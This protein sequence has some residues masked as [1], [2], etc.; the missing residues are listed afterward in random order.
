MHPYG[1]TALNHALARAAAM[2][3]AGFAGGWYN[4]LGGPLVVGNSQPAVHR[5]PGGKPYFVH[6][7]RGVDR[8]TFRA[9]RRTQLRRARGRWA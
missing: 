6:V 7:H 5:A 1:N 9:W 2:R 8:A 3:H 4:R